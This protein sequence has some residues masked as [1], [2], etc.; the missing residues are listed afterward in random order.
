M[1]SQD[2]SVLMAFPSEAV[3]ENAPDP[4]GKKVLWAVSLD[5]PK[6]V[7]KRAFISR[8]CVSLSEGV[9]GAIPSSDKVIP[10]SVVRS[11]H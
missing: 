5:L 11:D 3:R 7:P 1:E 9:C 4:S 10:G 2:Q 8:S 6:H